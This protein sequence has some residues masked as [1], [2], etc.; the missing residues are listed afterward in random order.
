MKLQNYKKDGLEL[1]IDLETG[2]TFASIHA[3]SRMTDKNEST[4]RSYVKS[5]LEAAR[6]VTL[7]EVEINTP[8]GL[9][10][11]RLFNEYQILEVVARYK[12]DL[13]IKFAQAG[14]RVFL[15]QLAGYQVNSTAVVQPDTQLTNRQISLELAESIRTITDTLDDNP[16]IAQLLIDNALMDIRQHQITGTELKGVVEIATS[17]GFKVDA[18]SRS[19]LGKFIKSCGFEPQ[20]EKRICNGQM[21]EINCYMETDELRNTISA[22]FD[23]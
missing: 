10:G 13:L 23:N 15:H 21:R 1:V 22:F 8:G 5:T 4:I 19:R 12:P 6:E 2:E 14:L 3:V 18:S 7:L 9:Q 20:K 11:A 17:M 16:R